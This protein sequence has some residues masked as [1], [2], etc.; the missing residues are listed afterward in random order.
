MSADHWE[1]TDVAYVLVVRPQIA[2]IWHDKVNGQR[3]DGS[4]RGAQ[5]DRQTNATKH[6]KYLPALQ[7]IIIIKY[8]SC[9][10]P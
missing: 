2:M 3:P 7:S 8:I 1:N 4:S 6:F 5:L 10:Y 9:D